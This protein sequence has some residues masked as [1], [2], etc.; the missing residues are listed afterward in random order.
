MQGA[1][2]LA[3][4]AFNRLRHLQSLPLW[5][6]VG[7][8]PPAALA[9]P[10]TVVPCGRL[11]LFA[12]RLPCLW[13]AF[14]PPIPLPPFP[15]G[16]GRFFSLF[17]RGLRPRHPCIKPFATLIVFSA[18][19]PCGRLAR[20]AARL[21]CLWFAFLPPIPPTPFPGGEGGVFFVFVFKGLRPLHP[22]HLTA[23]GTY[24]TCQAGARRGK[25]T[26][27]S[28]QNRQETSPYERCR[29]PRRGGTGGEELRRLRWSSPPGQGQQVPRGGKPPCP[30]A[31]TTAAGQAGDHPPCPPPGTQTAGTASAA[32]GSARG[33]REPPA[34]PPIPPFF[35]PPLDKTQ[36]YVYNVA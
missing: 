8:L 15:A 5:Y 16:R 34:Y 3:S 17:R 27:G 13:F 11:V 35:A 28:T 10:A 26:H 29:Q 18:V 19:V 23:C 4:P 31:G 32:R 6:P 20:F 7:G 36:A 9:I 21:P 2:P 22:Q 1:S 25:E 12:A 14:L 33:R 24:R 30:P